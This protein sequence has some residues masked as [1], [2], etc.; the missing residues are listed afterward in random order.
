MKIS[1]ANISKV[2]SIVAIIFIVITIVGTLYTRPIK[3]NKTFNNSIST[4]DL[5]SAS[6]GPTIEINGFI[7]K[8]LSIKDFNKQVILSGK[9]KIDNKSYDLFAYNLGKATNYVV[10]GEVKENSNDMYPKY[11]LF[12][13]DNYNSIYLTGF[14]SKHYIA[15]PAKTIDDIKNLQTKLQRKN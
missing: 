12:L 3:F 14:D 2:V 5:V 13:F 6:S 15:S 7:T 10:F 11:M 4:M 1:R 9:I 8:R